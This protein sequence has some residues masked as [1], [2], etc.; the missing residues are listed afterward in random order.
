MRLAWRMQATCLCLR[1]KANPFGNVTK[2]T[3][4]TDADLQPHRPEETSTT[5]ES[6]IHAG[7]AAEFQSKRLA[8]KRRK[9]SFMV[10]SDEDELVINS[11]NTPPPD[12]PEM[13]VVHSGDTA[14]EPSTSFASNDASSAIELG[15]N[16]ETR[17]EENF[18][19]F[20]CRTNERVRLGRGGNNGRASFRRWAI[21]LG[22]TREGRSNS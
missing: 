15:S 10:D 19:S 9:R 16:K 20:R 1:Q 12:H 8:R 14:D 11:P 2:S 22:C 6:S 4:I 13:Q 17:D 3:V 5:D 7:F 21:N 18:L